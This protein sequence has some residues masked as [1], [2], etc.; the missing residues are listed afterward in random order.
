MAS[1]PIV[2]FY[3]AFSRFFVKGLLQGGNKGIKT[4]RIYDF[5]C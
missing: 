5:K 2:L 3:L 4:L 1:L